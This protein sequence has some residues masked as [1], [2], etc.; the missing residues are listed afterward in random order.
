MWRQTLRSWFDTMCRAEL[1]ALIQHWRDLWWKRSTLRAAV[2]RLQ[3]GTTA[4]ALRQWHSCVAHKAAL[5]SRL[6]P[7]LAQWRSVRLRAGFNGFLLQVC[8]P[9]AIACLR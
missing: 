9:S 8:P 2:A 3:Q 1:T 6:E 7:I 4:R 5:R